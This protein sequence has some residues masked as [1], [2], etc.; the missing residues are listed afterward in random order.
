MEQ[1]FNVIETAD[2]ESVIGKVEQI[3]KLFLTEIKRQI[4]D[5]EIISTEKVDNISLI[6]ELL[7]DLQE[8]D[9]KEI[10]KVNYNPMG[11]YTYSIV[12]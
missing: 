9:D 6:M 3:R 2:N 1:E 4:N 8:E 12:E 10:I 7:E 5:K 11:V